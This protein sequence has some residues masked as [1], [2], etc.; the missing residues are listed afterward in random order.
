MMKDERG[1]DEK[2]LAMPVDDLHPLCIRIR[3]RCCASSARFFRHYKYLEP[4]KWVEGLI[5]TRL[6]LSSR[7]QSLAPWA[8]V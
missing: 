3:R 2:I 6:Q 1:P 7:R 4:G 8:E 5:L